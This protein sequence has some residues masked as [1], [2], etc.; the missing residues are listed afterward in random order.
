MRE[1]ERGLG[2]S[3]K[4]FFLFFFLTSISGHTWLALFLSNDATMFYSS[5]IFFPLPFFALFAFFSFRKEC[6]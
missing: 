3:H 4:L 2:S 6:I 1:R 5:D